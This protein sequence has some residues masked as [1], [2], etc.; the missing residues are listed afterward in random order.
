MTPY[1][2]LPVRMGEVSLKSNL[3][4]RATIFLIRAH[5]VRNLISAYW[6][7]GVFQVSGFCLSLLNDLLKICEF[8]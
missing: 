5:D 2:G 4:F 1:M 3:Q 6:R 8:S 7:S